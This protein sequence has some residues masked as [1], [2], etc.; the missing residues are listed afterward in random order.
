MF[1]RQK[2]PDFNFNLHV[3]GHDEEKGTASVFNGS[4]CKKEKKKLRS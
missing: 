4:F 2:L 1:V 3:V